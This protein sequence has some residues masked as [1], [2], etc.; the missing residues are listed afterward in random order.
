[1]S[2]LLDKI[3][4][5]IKVQGI[6]AKKL[7]A[8]T[9][10]SSSAITEWKK[11]KANPSAEAIVKIAEYFNV[12]TDFLLV[13]DYDTPISKT[14]ISPDEAQLINL[15]RGGYKR[16]GLPPEGQPISR[17]QELMLS[18]FEEL[19]DHDEDELERD[20]SILKSLKKK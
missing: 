17:R 14:N 18:L 4:Y 19:D 11:G 9:G 2:V 8:D 12:S 5:L 3:L 10:I 7:T 6:T 1:M 15:Y 20:L 13:D 16:N